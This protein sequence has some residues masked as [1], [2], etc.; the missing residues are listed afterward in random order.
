MG[1]CGSSRKRPPQPPIQPQPNIQPGQVVV[2]PQY[3]PP[4]FSSPYVPTLSPLTTTY[5]PQPP[6][7][8]MGSPINYNQEQYTPME[9]PFYNGEVNYPSHPSSVDYNYTVEQPNLYVPNQDQ[10]NT[11]YCENC[12]QRLVDFDPDGYPSDFC[13]DECRREAMGVG[14]S[15]PPCTQCK[16]FPRVKSSEFC[17]MLKCRNLPLCLTCKAKRAYPRSLW[18]SK[19]CRDRTPNWRQLVIERSNQLCLYCNRDRAI[20]G[21][22]FCSSQ[23]ES[24]VHS[25]APCMLKLPANSQK[26][27]DVAKQ[28]K[29]AWKHPHK[30]TPEISK[31]WKIYC[32]E[33][34][35]SR[36]RLYREEVERQ[37]QLAGKPFPKG[38]GKRL[39]SAGNE[40]RRFHG[41]KMSCLIG[42]KNDGQVCS[43]KSC[44]VCCII[45]D[46]Y[47][48]RYV[49]TG[50][51]FSRFGRGLYFSGTSSKS[52][53]YNDGSLKDFYGVSYKVM[54]LNKVVVG[55]GHPLTVDNMTLTAPPMGYD[56]VLGEPSTTGNLNYDEVVV[57]REEASIPQYLIVYKAQ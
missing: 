52:D 47:K 49:G 26:Y 12:K 53:D 17:G 27:K 51:V 41:T 44:S 36:Y 54:L 18:C 8:L 23:C 30:L 32:P 22:D 39:M 20:S 55:K 13:S 14:L 35:V 1:N 19:F 46:G 6:P 2:I 7:I 50:T 5:P 25:N 38:D 31:I 40:Q 28:F 42:L 10:G 3:Q 33:A 9:Q 24:F 29:D 16:E 56:S 57:Y 11:A 34:M 45:R 15:N 21:Q 4:N 48:L 37:Q 43:D